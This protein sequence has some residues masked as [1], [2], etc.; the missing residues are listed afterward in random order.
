MVRELHES[1][2]RIRLKLMGDQPRIV[3][4]KPESYERGGVAHDCVTDVRFE[5]VREGRDKHTL[6]VE[7]PPG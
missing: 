2:S 5:L 4:S 3:R 6:G 1:G 7:T